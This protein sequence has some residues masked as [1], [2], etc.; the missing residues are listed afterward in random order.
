MDVVLDE[1]NLQ[2]VSRGVTRFKNVQVLRGQTAR[3]ERERNDSIE[4][5]NFREGRNVDT[6]A[7]RCLLLRFNR[8]VILCSSLANFED[9]SCRSCNSGPIG[10]KSTWR[11]L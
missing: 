3:K 4:G 5:D 8:R 6:I 9:L 1:A 11:D 2:F 7:A 10:V